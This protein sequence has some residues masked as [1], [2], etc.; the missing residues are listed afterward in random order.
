MSL[1][2]VGIDRFPGQKHVKSK[3]S[4]WNELTAFLVGLGSALGMK[5]HCIVDLKMYVLR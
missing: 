3:A 2:M 5:L 4:I 1:N